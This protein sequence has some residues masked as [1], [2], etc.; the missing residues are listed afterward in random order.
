MEVIV[1]LLTE[2]A[3]SPRTHQIRGLFNHPTFITDIVTMESPSQF[4]GSKLNYS[5][6]LER[7]RVM[8]C[9]N[10]A[11]TEYPLS[12][13]IIVKDTTVS[14]ASPETIGCRISQILSSSG[15]DLCYLC[16]W[17]DRCDLYT[18]KKTLDNGTTMVV[19]TQA[20]QGFQAVLLTPEGRDKLLSKKDLSLSLQDQ[21]HQQIK[22]DEL[23][24]IAIVPNLLNYDQNA[25]KENQKYRRTQECLVPGGSPPN[26]PNAGV[27]FNWL[28]LI[29]IL[30]I[31]LILGGFAYYRSYA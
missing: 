29:L 21:I 2:N 24:V 13:I 17:L 12:P 22:S 27:G 26:N 28:W 16:K 31:I 19:K 1:Y 9:L 7:H 23:K 11:K 30:I 10:N 14:V 6:N 5:D 15:W 18:E 4:P 20:P 8:W 3:D 25:V